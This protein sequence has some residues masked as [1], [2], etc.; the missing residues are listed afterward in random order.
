M[1]AKGMTTRQASDTLMDIHGVEAS[2]GFISDV[3]DKFL[4]QIEEWQNE[5]AKYW[6]SMLNSLRDRSIRDI[7]IVCV[8]EL[9]GS[10][11]IINAVF[12]Q[13]EYQ[14]CVVHQVCNTLKYVAD[15]DSKSLTNLKKIYYTPGADH[16]AEIRDTA[17]EKMVEKYPNAMKS[18][19]TNWDSITSHIYDLYRFRDST[20]NAIESLNSTYRKLNRQRSVFPSD[21]TLLKALYLATFK[22]TNK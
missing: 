10:R 12:P 3:T 20:T 13:T 17:A 1:Y 14:H 18:W 11:E 21:Q 4:P 7:L 15:K 19:A 22:A 2:K 16:V 9:T 5:S 8:N 6:L